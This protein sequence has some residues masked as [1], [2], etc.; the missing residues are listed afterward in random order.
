MSIFIILKT[1]IKFLTKT[2]RSNKHFKQNNVRFASSYIFCF[3]LIL[4]VPVVANPVDLS[5]TLG[6]PPANNSAKP[7]GIRAAKELISPLFAVPLHVTGVFGES[8][9]LTINTWTFHISN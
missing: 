2:R 8:I 6:M 9:L 4:T 3:T 1:K 5:W 7:L